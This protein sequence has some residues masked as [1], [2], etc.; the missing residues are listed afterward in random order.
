M[1]LFR[2]AAVD[3][4]PRSPYFTVAYSERRPSWMH[5]GMTMALLDGGRKDLV[6]VG[7]LSYQDNLWRIA[8]SG[9]VPGLRV[10]KEICAMLVPETGN[11]DDSEAVS[12]W[13][14]G[15]RVG[16]LS[17]G[18]A[19]RFRPGV[20][21]LQERHGQPI[22]LPGVVVG[23][24]IRDDGAGKLGVFLEHDPVDF[25]LLQAHERRQTAE[26]S[27]P[28]RQ[29]HGPQRRLDWIFVPTRRLESSRQRQARAFAAPGDLS[30]PV[31]S[32]GT[33]R[34]RQRQPGREARIRD[35]GSHSA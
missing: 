19:R 13:I 25:S 21:A 17:R 18:D 15:L 29:L 20:L 1:G 30:I 33:Q 24:G 8:G 7:E 11:P 3:A 9:P 10:R 14:S 27:A 35:H 6:I 23:G 4:K 28:L 2:K 5:D 16:H 31:T 34:A 22:G 26:S 12:V 32:S